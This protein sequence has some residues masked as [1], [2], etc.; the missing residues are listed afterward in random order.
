MRLTLR[1]E[2]RAAVI[3]T[4]A[5]AEKAGRCPLAIAQALY[6][7]IP[8]MVLGECYASLQMAE[9]DAWW[10]ALERTIDAEVIRHAVA[11]SGSEAP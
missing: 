4:M 9:E 3:A 1:A 8:T 10:E 7:G 2:V 5:E 6:P 11:A